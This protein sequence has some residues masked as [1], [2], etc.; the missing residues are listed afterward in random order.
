MGSDDACLMLPNFAKR[1][2]GFI[3]DAAVAVKWEHAVRKRGSRASATGFHK[4]QGRMR[5]MAKDDRESFGGGRRDGAW[6][7]L[8]VPL[9]RQRLPGRLVVFDGIDGSGKSTHVRRLHQLFRECGIPCLVTS[10]PSNELRKH[11]GWRDWH[12]SPEARSDIDEFGLTLM[13]LGDRLINQS[14]L[15][16]P[17]LKRGLVVLSDRY[18]L[19]VLAYWATPVHKYALRSLLAPD[20]GIY[21]CVDPHTAAQRAAS[22]AEP[23]HLRREDLLRVLQHRYE[24]LL[25]HYSYRTLDTSS[26]LRTTG[27]DCL[28]L[29][30]RILPT[31]L[32]LKVM[33]NGWRS[34]AST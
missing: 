19:S 33:R 31:R 20:L 24:L 3:V 8:Q 29:V 28:A 30:S 34:S 23:D 26:D 14:S 32:R 1:H 9:R 22:R 13:A 6:K 7:P 10:A 12:A 15:V 5:S 17:A 27:A 4:P 18:V 25:P 21:C 16:L 2:S 11:S